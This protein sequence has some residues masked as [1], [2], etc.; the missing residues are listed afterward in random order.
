MASVRRVAFSSSI[1]IDIGATR[2]LKRLPIES[3]RGI[4]S[5]AAFAPVGADRRISAKVSGTNAAVSHSSDNVRDR[6]DVRYLCIRRYG[7]V[8]IALQQ[9]LPNVPKIP[10]QYT[11]HADT[12]GRRAHADAHGSGSRPRGICW[13]GMPAGSE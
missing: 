3:S 9:A 7:V 5:W 1:H 12:S 6:Q 8:R 11:A 10:R 13:G 2:D 4:S